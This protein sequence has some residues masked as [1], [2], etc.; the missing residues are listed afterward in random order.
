M[1]LLSMCATKHVSAATLISS[2][3]RMACATK[4]FRNCFCEVGCCVEILE[5]ENLVWVCGRSPS[6]LSNREH[7]LRSRDLDA[8]CR[9]A[10][11][12]RASDIFLGP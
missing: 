1:A 2:G 5:Y 12:R 8:K 3:V 4:T 7:S 11:F 10:P 9:D 6:T